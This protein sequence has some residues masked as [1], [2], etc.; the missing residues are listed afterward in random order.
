MFPVRLVPRDL[1]LDRDRHRRRPRTREFE[2]DRPPGLPEGVP[3]DLPVALNL[4]VVSLA[5]GSR[6]R[7]EL[8]IDGHH[9]E[10]W[11]AGFTTR[12]QP[13]A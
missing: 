4:G 12:T 5:P 11:E 8:S 6:Y 1:Y 7:W 3:L 9:D 13:P 2:A 10:A